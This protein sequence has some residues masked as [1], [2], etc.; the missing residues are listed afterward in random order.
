MRLN[1][2][3]PQCIALHIIPDSIFHRFHWLLDYDDDNEY[4][5]NNNDDDKR[6]FAA[7]TFP[8]YDHLISQ[9]T[10]IDGD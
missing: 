1:F 10:L 2:W 4:D 5:G 3:I 9:S 8:S 6:S 7:T